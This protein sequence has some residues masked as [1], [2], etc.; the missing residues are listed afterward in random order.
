MTA[1]AMG[2]EDLLPDPTPFV[3]DLTQAAYLAYKALSGHGGV[4]EW[5]RAAFLALRAIPRALAWLE[6][7][8]S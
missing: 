7:L 1:Y 5:L 6:K 3:R 4:F 2:R 8:F